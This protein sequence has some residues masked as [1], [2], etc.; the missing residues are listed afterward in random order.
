MIQIKEIPVG[1]PAKHA[2]NI[3]IRVMPFQTNAN[4]C[5]TY[6]ELISDLLITDEEGNTTGSYEVL[7]DGNSPITEEQFANWGADN[8][9]IED[10]VL[11]NLFLER[12]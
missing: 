5:N 3:T 12:S 2:N 8:T 7:A 9:Y 11:A 10:I 1:Y 6:Y 4:K